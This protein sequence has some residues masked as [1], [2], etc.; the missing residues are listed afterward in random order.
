MDKRVKGF[1]PIMKR[2]KIVGRSST[3]SNAFAQALAP[4]DEFSDEKL[5]A[6]FTSI[7][8]LGD[9]GLECAY[10]GNSAAQVDHLNPLV[11]DSKFTGWGHVLGNLVP[12]CNSCNQ[13]K[14]GKP[15]REFA[16]QVGVDP[17][18]IELIE[19]YESLAPEP[20][21]Q[22]MLREMYPDLVEAYERMRVLSIEMLRAAQHLA[23][24]I[25]SLESARKTGLGD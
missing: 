22:D 9:D 5:I 15:W 25:H 17:L 13:S 16:S 12:A 7:G 10:C 11:K 21:S 3:I 4:S 18:R 24:E 19:R 2:Y 1:K 23:N 14:G 6:A 20:I 8:L